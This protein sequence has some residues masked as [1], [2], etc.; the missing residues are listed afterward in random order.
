MAMGSVKGAVIT[1]PLTDKEVNYLRANKKLVHQK[2]I[3]I[4]ALALIVNPANPVEIL[5]KKISLK[6]SL[7]MS[8]DGIR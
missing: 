8:H 3:A 2:K 1:R 5:S 7:E 6:Y 4:D